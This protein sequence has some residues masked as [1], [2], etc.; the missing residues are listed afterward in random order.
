IEAEMKKI[1]KANQ[2]LVKSSL[3]IKEAISKF[4]SEG[5]TYKVEI[6]KALQSAGETEVTL[7][8]EGDFA[9]LCKGPHIMRAGDIGN[10]WKL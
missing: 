6:I 5:Q 10:G 8:T 4:E 2:Q 1:A 3:P 9:D 7:F